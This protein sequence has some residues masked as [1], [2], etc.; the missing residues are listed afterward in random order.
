MPRPAKLDGTDLPT[1]LL[2]TIIHWFMHN[3]LLIRLNTYTRRQASK[4]F[5]VSYKS[6]RESFQKFGKKE[7]HTTKGWNRNRRRVR[8]RPPR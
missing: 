3:N 5:G 2:G 4:D 7:G 6:L 8:T 1:K